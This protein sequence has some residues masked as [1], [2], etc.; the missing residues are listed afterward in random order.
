MG[1]GREGG[2]WTARKRARDEAGA[3][4]GGAPPGGVRLFGAGGSADDL[5]ALAGMD[6][7][8]G[9]A[10]RGDASG[11]GLRRRVQL[12]AWVALGVAAVASLG[13]GVA[14]AAAPGGA[15][16]ADSAL[17]PPALCGVSLAAMAAISGL[18]VASSRRF[19]GLRRKALARAFYVAVACYAA[20]SL[21]LLIA[22]V[23]RLAN[24]ER[25][26]RCREPPGC[27]RALPELVLTGQLLV[28]VGSMALLLPARQ[29]STR[30]LIEHSVLQHRAFDM[31]AIDV[32]T[33]AS[34]A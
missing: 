32:G 27:A 12:G 28:F 31:G 2:A 13:L 4:V 29:H 14:S 1:G 6:G 33:Y 25:R 7:A 21:I 9:G 24:K 22:A 23:A 3:G 30:L 16:T 26:Q 11:E 19:A 10:G 34:M 8:G 5:P 18:G 15:L 20:W 17:L